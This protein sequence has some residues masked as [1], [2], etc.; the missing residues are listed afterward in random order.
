[1]PEQFIPG[2]RWISNTESDLGLGSVLR[3]EGRR[4]ALAFP[5]SG[6]QRIYA[7]DNAPLTRVRFSP[8]DWIETRDGHR[9]RVEQVEERGGLIHYL[10]TS[11]EGLEHHCPEGELSNTLQLSRPQERLLSGQLDDS[12]WF[13]LR[14]QTHQQLQRLDRS[15]LL[16]LGGARTELL[17]HQLYIAHEVSRRA[18]PRV[19]LADEVGLGKTI[20]A[21]LILHQ[22]LLTG[23]ASR[24]LIM[25]PEPLLHQWLVELLR[26]FN[27][28]FSIFDEERCQAIEASGEGDKPFSAE[29]L[30][31]C[32]P[33]LFKGNYER[34]KQLVTGEW[35]LVIVDEAHHL[36]WSEKDASEEYLLVEALSTVSPGLLL[37]TA[38]PEQ[39]G[40]AGH[41]AR[42]RL[43]DPDRFHS[44]EIF[45]QEEAQYEPIAEVVDLLLEGKTLDK[46]AA[47]VLLE[48]LHETESHELISRWNDTSA[49]ELERNE[50]IDMLLDRHGTSRILFRNT[51]SR[52]KGFPGR[53][54][55]R[56]PLPLPDQYAAALESDQ[57]DAAAA[58]TP[59]LLYRAHAG[60]PWWRFD[61][62]I[63]W[64]ITLLG[65][66]DGAKVLMICSSAETAMEIGEALK[67]LEGINA[68]LFHE[69]MSIMERDRTAAWF[70]DPEE[71]C[72]LLICSE[73]GSEGRN[74]QFAH[75]LIMFDLPLNPDLLEQRIGR[76]D[77]IG[78]RETIQIHV[79]YFEE[80]SQAVLLRWYHE[81]LNAFEHT[82]PSGHAVFSQLKP[83]L[84][85]AL[86]ESETDP[87]QIEPLINTTRILREEADEH[88]KKG[89]DHLLEINSCREQEAEEIKQHIE[90][91][92]NPLAL[93]AYAHHLFA[94]IGVESEEHSAGSLILKPG[95]HMVTDSLPALPQDG[96]TCTFQRRI[97]LS[98]EDRHFLT[99]EHPLM[100]GTMEMVTDMELGNSC[101]V[102]I[103]HPHLKA[104][105][106]LLE[107]LYT[108]ECPAPKKL[109]AGRFLENTVTRLLIDQQ[110]NPI[111]DRLNHTEINGAL[112]PLE[113]GTILK[114]IT[115]L[116]DHITA[117]V[118]RGEEQ[119]EPLQQR[120]VEE[121]LA[122]TSHHF[123][124]ER[125]RLESLQKVN[126]NIRDEEVTMLVYQQ[127]LLDAHLKASRM[128]LDA[129]RLIVSL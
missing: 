44:L 113:K 76:L 13:E 120:A 89:R 65:R 95:T 66:L 37:L 30:V 62:R 21:C 14:L 121:A 110:L 109:Q 61:P 10:G 129:L 74:F 126:P 115:A 90:E 72:Q 60:T 38:T 58:L 99:W 108:L 79:P 19:L 36:E 3:S 55:H 106:L 67:T 51:R 2:Q 48:K 54:L 91:A 73:I 88:L 40:S 125:E 86:E 97:A 22:Q 49:H 45:Q 124:H 85:Q 63:A 93:Q 128:R 8:G 7:V 47:S 83:A 25:V 87:E 33:T 12:R 17:L 78:Q 81:G 122:Q 11:S 18:A 23:Q 52:I 29:Q 4:V 127:E 5:A 24:V 16:G 32:S 57:P 1:M 105:T 117:M 53:E 94:L 69:G 123:D 27:L 70:A 41:F 46:D 119:A 15:H 59:E 114:I 98:H 101:V 26:K 118:K 103:K 39:L 31:L 116:R 92:E 107:M 28:H 80:T 64:L 104:G 84:I 35:D 102:A 112:V 111:S 34:Q 68:G 43:L 96:M 50:L 75:H 20:E 71:G 6:E 100:R 56:H 82:S 77:R 9:L 42:L